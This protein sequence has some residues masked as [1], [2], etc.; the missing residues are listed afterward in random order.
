MTRL[1]IVTVWQRTA[2][3]VVVD[4]TGGLLGVIEN[5]DTSTVAKH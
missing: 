3:E 2:F 1:E 4:S 5:G